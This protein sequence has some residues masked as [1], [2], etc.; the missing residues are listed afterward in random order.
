MNST[1]GLTLAHV[2]FY[3]A[4]KKFGFAEAGRH[5]VF[6]HMSACRDV[7]GTPEEHQLTNRRCE[8]EPRWRKGTRQLEWIVVQIVDGP[9]GPKAA[10]WGYKPTRTWLEDLAHFGRLNSFATGSI[11]ICYREQQFGNSHRVSE[12]KLA[13]APQ[14]SLGVQPTLRVQY[15]AY[16][17]DLG[18]YGECTGHSDITFDMADAEPCKLSHS[19]YGVDVRLP[20]NSGWAHIV[21]YPPGHWLGK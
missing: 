1:N 13:A 4:A 2:S 15:D 14:L 10:A 17:S 19:M 5:R 16:D 6:F 9:K 7:E 20:H 3:D 8:R 12:G 21:F 11:K 18:C